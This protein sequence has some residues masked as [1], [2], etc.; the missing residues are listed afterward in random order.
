MRYPVNF[1]YIPFNPI[2]YEISCKFITVPVEV[3]ILAYS[4]Q[5]LPELTPDPYTPPVQGRRRINQGRRL[6]DK[7]EID[8]E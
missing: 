7:A 3:C 5:F 6:A 2:I 1:V 4:A 8:S